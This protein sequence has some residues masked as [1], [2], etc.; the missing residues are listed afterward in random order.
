MPSKSKNKYNAYMKQ[1]MRAKREVE[2][3]RRYYGLLIQEF[4]DRTALPRHVYALR[5]VLNEMLKGR[6]IGDRTD[7]IAESYLRL[8]DDYMVC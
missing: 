2:I 4:K 3:N 1:Y 8:T 7:L 6:E 5:Q